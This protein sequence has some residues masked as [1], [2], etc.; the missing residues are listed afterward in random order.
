M[1]K[2]Y[3][4]W[5]GTIIEIINTATRAELRVDGKTQ[6]YT[7]G[8]VVPKGKSIRLEAKGGRRDKIS[9][10]FERSVMLF[11]KYTIYYNKKKIQ[12]GFL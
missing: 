9:V 3:K 7:E 4:E 8:L 5:E 10:V 12:S 11:T 6:D 2:I 1:R